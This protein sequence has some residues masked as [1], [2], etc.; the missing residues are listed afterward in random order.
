MSASRMYTIC[1]VKIACGISHTL[2]LTNKGKVYVW[3]ANKLV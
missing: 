1:L 3:G 2:A